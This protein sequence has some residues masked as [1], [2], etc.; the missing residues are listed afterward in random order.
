MAAQIAMIG[1]SF[2]PGVAPVPDE[3][4]DP[5]FYTCR[6][7]CSISVVQSIRVRANEDDAE[8]E[9]RADDLDGAS[10]LDLGVV[11][12]GVRFTNVTIPSDAFIM[13]AAIQFTADANFAGDNTAPLDL[14]VFAVAA[15]D[16]P[17]FGSDFVPL[18][19]LS[20]TIASVG[21]VVPPWQQQQTTAAQRTPNLAAVVQEVVDTPGWKTG[22]SIAIIFTGSGGRREAESH[23]GNPARAA[24]LE[25]SY[26][27]G[28]SQGFDVCMPPDINPNVEGN[29]IPNE[30][31]LQNDCQGRVEDTVRGVAASCQYPPQCECGAILDSQ[32]FNAACND[33]CAE[34]PVDVT[35][36]NFDPINNTPSATNVPGTL[37]VCVAARS[38][39]S[40]SGP[41][42]ITAAAF[43]QLS[44]CAVEGP[45]TIE[46]G[47][48]VKS[49]SAFGV[50]GFIGE[51]CPGEQCMVGLTYDLELDP[52][53]F[54]VR[55]ASDPTFEDLTSSGGSN[56]AAAVVGPSGFGTLSAQSTDTSL[57]GR[58]DADTRAY[59]LTNP[60]PI[61]IFIDWENHTCALFG[62]V[63]GTVD[64]E[65]QGEEAL[66]AELSVQG[67]L[68]NTP[69]T[70]DAGT[71]TETEC[72]SPQGATLLLDGSGSSDL[73]DNIVLLAWNRD[74][75]VGTPVGAGAVVEIEQGLG[76]QTTYY[77]RAIDAHG[78][79]DEDFVVQ[80]VVD[81]TA[82]DLSLSVSPAVLWPPNHKLT[83]VE[84]DLVVQDT[85]DLNPVIRL[86]SISS[87]EGDLANGTGNTSPDIQGADFGTDDRQFLLRAERR[88]AGGGR[89][90][91]I[92]YE[93]EDADGN[94]ATAT[95][96]VVVPAN[97]P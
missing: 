11:P 87:N 95:A 49:S 80:S 65:T 45:V 60:D 16:A 29:D 5:N 59:E 38:A 55:F 71:D 37:P 85:C 42:G 7:D 1:C 93:V 33:P 73:E 12:V 70:A 31:S 4:D 81:T 10:D 32:R 28:T 21:W 39:A 52:I 41:A 26:I 15:A 53:T 88:G 90:Y 63:A 20:R 68:L 44:D 54:E 18:T 82:P 86:V 94:I 91:T 89:V 35:C 75:R 92:T 58:R 23:N 67:T 19:A 96:A 97:Q 34:V 69:P 6:C 46:V 8:Q 51:P 76:E 3:L 27:V 30:T 84:V 13:S 77:L 56:A 64:G 50:V 61:G 62:N 78:Q 47:D 57:R 2:E 66:S 25:L 48:E 40:P 17:S 74:G 79:S 9:L 83:A 24:L 43:G 22:N 72:T 36:T 14:N